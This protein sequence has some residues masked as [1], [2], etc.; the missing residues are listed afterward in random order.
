M[1]E[2]TWAALRTPSLQLMSKG[3]TLSS[4]NIPMVFSTANYKTLLCHI[5]RSRNL[6]NLNMAQ[7]LWRKEL[8]S[9]SEKSQLFHQIPWHKK[10]AITSTTTPLPPSVCSVVFWFWFGFLQHTLY[11]HHHSDLDRMRPRVTQPT[12]TFFS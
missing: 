3:S 5:R 7:T 12:C 2:I 4:L 1:Q 8:R 11:H 9:I 6:E 10:P